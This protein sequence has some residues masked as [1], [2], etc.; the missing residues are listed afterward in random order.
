[1][2][3][4]LKYLVIVEINIMKYITIILLFISSICYGQSN[5][6]IM[7]EKQYFNELEKFIITSDFWK[8][9]TKNFND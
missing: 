8:I 1:M 3:K 6:P 9:V 5:E 7:T 2:I 4:N